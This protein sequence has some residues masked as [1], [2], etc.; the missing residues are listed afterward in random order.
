MTQKKSRSIDRTEETRKN[1][2]N[3]IQYLGRSHG[4]NNVFTTFLELAANHIASQKGMKNAEQYKRRFL[5]LTRNIP[6]EELYVYGVMFSALLL[7][8]TECTEEPHDIL[9]DTYHKLGLA[10][11]WKGQFFT[12]D[13]VC[14]LMAQ[15]ALPTTERFGSQERITVNEPACGS[16]AT[17]LGAVWAIRQKHIDCMRNSFFVAQDVDIRCVWMTYIQL[18]LYKVPA[19]VIHGNTLTGQE[20]ER[21]YTPLVS[22]PIAGLNFTVRK[23]SS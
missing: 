16:G 10:N 3:A 7:E 11:E 5:E 19:V 9:G 15:M 2:I 1:L 6:E 4:I 21:W 20:W 8:A 12:P 14:R 18:S 17:I 22:I 13:C 23:S